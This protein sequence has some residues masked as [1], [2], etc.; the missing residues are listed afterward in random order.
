MA[1]REVYP[2]YRENPQVRQLR[3]LGT[4]KGSQASETDAV[5]PSRLREP[6][7]A[8]RWPEVPGSEEG[9]RGGAACEPRLPTRWTGMFIAP[10]FLDLSPPGFLRSVAAACVVGMKERTSCC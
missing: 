3:G 2:E 4:G 8:Q 5:R 6:P 1:V 9:A 10:V 7:A